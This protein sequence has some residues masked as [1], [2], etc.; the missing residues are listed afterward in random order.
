MSI[1][2]L[3][4]A[5]PTVFNALIEGVRQHLH[6]Q[7]GTET[8]QPLT[9]VARDRDGNLIGGVSGRT[10]YRN[11]L[12]EVAWVAKEQRNTGLGR[13]LMARA[14]AEARNRGCLVAQV[15]TLSVQA[16][17]FYQKLGFATVGTVPGF[18]GSPAR[19]FLLKQYL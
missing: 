12:I 14:E 8:T 19:H 18:E 15:D 6:E 4:E 9:L 1:E 17:G 3:N 7:M 10:I 13:K 16:P 11:F 5:D 2:V